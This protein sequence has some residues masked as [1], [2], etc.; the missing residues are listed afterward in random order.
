[1][2]LLVMMTIF[3]IL[4]VDEDDDDGDDIMGDT[5]SSTLSLVATIFCCIYDLC[6]AQFALFEE[7][8]IFVFSYFH[9]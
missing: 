8:C 3:I 9:F 5:I 6:P 7:L 2:N 4:T 1:M